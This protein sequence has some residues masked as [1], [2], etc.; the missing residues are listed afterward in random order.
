S[1][2]A[3][4]HFAGVLSSCFLEL[5]VYRRALNS[6]PTR[7]SSDLLW[8]RARER[9][10]TVASPLSGCW[11]RRRDPLR[12]GRRRRVR[13]SSSVARR[14][15]RDRKSTRLNSSHVKNSYAVFCLE[16]KTISTGAILLPRY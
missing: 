3:F 4:A 1:A 9:R 14:R 10:R 2:L 15:R 12:D 13:R 5:A 8:G 11:L 7:R 16:K 6:F